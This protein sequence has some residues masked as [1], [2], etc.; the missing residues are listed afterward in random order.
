MTKDKRL[1]N[2]NKWTPTWEGHMQRIEDYAMIGNCRT[3]ALVCKSGSIDW[4]C[5]PYFNSASCFSAL[6]G[7]GR[8]GFWQISPENPVTEVSR[9]YRDQSMTL[10]TTFTTE[11]GKVRLTDCMSMEEDSTDILR[12]VECIEGSVM[13]TF[14]CTP[15]FDYGRLVPLVHVEND[16]LIKMVCGPDELSLRGSVEFRHCERKILSK[17]HMAINEK[18]AFQLT[19]KPSHISGSEALDAE[20]TMRRA[21][22]FWKNWI[23]CSHLSEGASHPEVVERSM[24]ILKA[25]T[26]D[27]TGSLVAA[28]T[29]SLPESIGEIRNWDYR[30]CWPRDS[31]LAIH[32]LVGASDQLEEIDE[33][34]SWLMRACSGIPEQMRPLYGLFGEPVFKE[35]VIE[36]LPGYEDSKPVR[37]GN[38]A[39][40]QL[41]LDIFLAAVEAFYKAEKLGLPRLEGSWELVNSILEFLEEKWREPDEGIWEVRGPRRHFVHSKA[42]VWG[43]FHYAIK[44]AHELNIPGDSGH[45]KRMADIIRQDILDKGFDSHLNSFVQFYGSKDVDSSLLT[46][47]IIG[48]V[49]ANDPRMI[50]TVKRIER[51]LMISPNLLMRYRPNEDIEGL[52]TMG[53]R[54]FLICSAWLGKVYALQGNYKRALDILNSLVSVTNDVGLLAEQYDHHT[55]RLLGNFP[56]AFSHIGLL[57]LELALCDGK[58]AA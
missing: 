51:E 9:K 2:I 28:A 56:Q 24:M 50:G 31:A 54:S 52:P 58:S 57:M 38:D 4:F 8:H 35:R 26:F 55:E 32:V 27:P 17:F 49:E 40:N 39:R 53:N 23:S 7:N 16:G 20:E 42:M 5:A 36:W 45:W 11:T 3:A 10:E 37:I 1:F 22:E 18:H 19:W 29:T 30:F 15:R 41:Q 25:L 34:R 14:E 13:M 44:A 21:D 46:L 43:A 12:V 48:F 47:P 33:W 6:L